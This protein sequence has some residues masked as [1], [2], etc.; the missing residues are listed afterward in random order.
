MEFVQSRSLIE[1]DFEENLIYRG[2]EH[3][4]SRNA[5]VSSYERS[6]AFSD[7]GSR[8][9]LFYLDL[10]ELDERRYAVKRMAFWSSRQRLLR[11]KLRIN[12]RLY[13]DEWANAQLEVRIDR[14]I[15]DSS[16]RVK[17]LLQSE[18]DFKISKTGEEFKEKVI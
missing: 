9:Q 8:S 6:Y 14:T 15:L 13:V 10:V 7:T 5:S 3:F 1:S 16:G 17:V 18:R 11:A 2:T 12:S 4:N